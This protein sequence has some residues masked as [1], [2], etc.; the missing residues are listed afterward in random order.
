MRGTGSES[1]GCTGEKGPAYE[2]TKSWCLGWVKSTDP[3]CTKAPEY[4]YES[5]EKSETS[6]I[7]ANVR[8][9][10]GGGYILRIRG[11]ITDMQKNIELLKKENW[12]DNRT[13]AL[14]VEF[15]VYNAQ[16]ALF[17]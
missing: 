10:G 11:Y 7:S 5:A 2:D 14:I 8:S 12:I 17:F 13:R 16:V 6:D 1:F 9:Y 15:S 4:E 3:N